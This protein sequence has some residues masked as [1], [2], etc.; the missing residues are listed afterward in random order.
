MFQAVE[1]A[2]ALLFKK[3]TWRLKTHKFQ[4]PSFEK[5]AWEWLHRERDRLNSKEIKK[6]ESNDI[7]EE[8][9]NNLREMSLDKFA[10]E[11]EEMIPNEFDKFHKDDRKSRTKFKIQEVIDLLQKP[12]GENVKE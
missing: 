7:Q 12:R 9:F 4:D 3:S 6:V 11:L 1:V 8:F 5:E 10:I 2:K